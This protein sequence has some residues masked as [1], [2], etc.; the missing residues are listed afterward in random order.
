[1]NVLVKAVAQIAI[2]VFVGNAAGEAAHK[3]NDKI[4]KVVAAKKEKKEA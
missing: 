3:M 1:M 2:G 4:K